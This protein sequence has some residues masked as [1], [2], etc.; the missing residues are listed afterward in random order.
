MINE[1]HIEL[2]HPPEVGT[3]SFA[4][5]RTQNYVHVPIRSLEGD[6]KPGRTRQGVDES[7]TMVA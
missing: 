7:T 3:R 5:G 6:Q 2:C 4:A 1:C